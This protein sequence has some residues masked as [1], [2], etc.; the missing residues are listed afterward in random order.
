MSYTPKY[1]YI[2]ER[3]GANYTHIV[4][5]IFFSLDDD[6]AAFLVLHI[7]GVF[8]VWVFLGLCVT[9]LAE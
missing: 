7:Y 6:G 5:R 9:R 3:L 8:F 4:W 2:L 1:A